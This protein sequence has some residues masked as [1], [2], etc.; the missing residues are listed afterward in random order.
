MKILLAVTVIALGGCNED[1]SQKCDYCHVAREGAVR[2]FCDACK[3]THVA[4]PVEKAI[5]HYVEKGSGRFEYWSATSTM[6]CPPPR[7]LSIE[8]EPPALLPIAEKDVEKGNSPEKKRDM[9]VTFFLS[10][11]VGLGCYWRGRVD[12]RRA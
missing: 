9:I 5:L 7:D 1:P 12:G 2:Y 3:S 10:F 6:A 8:I 4:C 11:F